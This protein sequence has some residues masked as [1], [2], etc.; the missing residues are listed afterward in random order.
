MPARDIMVDRSIMPILVAR[1]GDRMARDLMQDLAASTGVRGDIFKRLAT[2]LGSPTTPWREE[3]DP[4]T[5]RLHYSAMIR[6][7]T[8]WTGTRLAVES[9]LPE[10]VLQAIVGM[11][12]SAV[13][14][15]PLLP[16]NRIVTGGTNDDGRTHI[17]V[18]SDE[19]AARA[20]AGNPGRLAET[21]MRWR[22]IGRRARHAPRETRLLVTLSLSFLVASL[23]T[24][25]HFGLTLI[26]CLSIQVAFAS[27]LLLHGFLKEM[28]GND[29]DRD[30]LR[31][32]HAARTNLTRET[33]E[34]GFDPDPREYAIL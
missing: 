2:V 1:V 14:A 31:L 28:L 13:V 21:R 32:Y 4:S 7:G 26:G 17:D 3:I 10:T 8:H 20:L 11:P 15:H 33:I 30:E 27:M 12:L 22:A 34:R 9:Q 18:E 29:V 24:A 25:L 19:V 23:L 5:E 16:A 6:A